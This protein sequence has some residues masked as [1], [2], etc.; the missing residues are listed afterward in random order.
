M[1]PIGREIVAIVLIVFGAP[2]AVLGIIGLGGHFAM[3]LAGVALLVLAR[4]LG[5]RRAD[6]RPDLR[7]LPAADDDDDGRM[8][9]IPK[10]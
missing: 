9:V 6:E 7:V 4:R 1:T 2:L 10:R 3:F 5:T 8:E